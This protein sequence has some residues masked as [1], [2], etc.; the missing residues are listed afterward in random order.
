VVRTIVQLGRDL[1]LAVL[2]EG[3]E[4]QEQADWLREVGCQEAQGFLFY[5]AVDAV[6]LLALLPR[7]NHA[8]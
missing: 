3:V 1:D 7:L 4:T 6:Q 2:A 8:L 5:S